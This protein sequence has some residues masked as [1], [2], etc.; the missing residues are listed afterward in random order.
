MRKRIYRTTAISFLALLLCLPAAAQYSYRGDQADFSVYEEDENY[1]VK[2]RVNVPVSSSRK[3]QRIHSKLRLKAID[4]IGNYIVLNQ[5]DLPLEDR[6]GLMQAFVDNTSMRFSANV[7]RVKSTPWTF[8]DK[9][10]CI[11]F[12]CAKKDFE[13]TD[14]Y[15]EQDF[16]IAHILYMNFRRNRDIKSACDYLMNI[17][18]A[19]EEKIW[20]ELQFL[21]G[22]AEINP[23]VSRL[24]AINPAYR[25]ENSLYHNDSLQQVYVD[26]IS[27]QEKN[28]C[29][30]G[31]MITARIL[32]TS[33]GAEYKNA[34]FDEYLYHLGQLDGLWYQLVKYAA[35]SRPEP[36][37]MNP[38]E[39]AVFEVIGAYPMGPNPYGMR[40]GDNGE[41]YTKATEAFAEED[42]EK[43]LEM[44]ENEINFNGI[45]ATNLNLTGACYRL[46]EDYRQALPYLMMAY[47]LNNEAPYVAGN[48]VLCLHELDYPELEKINSYFLDKNTIDPWSKNQIENLTKQD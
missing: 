2:C 38:Q 1:V 42:T 6:S 13:V 21:G 5:L 36:E 19:T 26:S 34:Y 47:Y 3:L 9:Q 30:F 23:L 46:L 20:A 40:I 4:L 22:S 45:N 25:L 35:N 41:H 10:R 48:L 11:S 18:V 28:H 8:C 33:A 24:L 7:D 27:M 43:A 16:D 14:R 44:L 32:F 31:D 39:M 12:R 15:L 17:P 29:A 37:S